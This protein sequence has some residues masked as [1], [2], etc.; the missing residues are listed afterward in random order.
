MNNTNN[1]NTNIQFKYPYI[2]DN[3]LQKKIALKKEFQYKYDD[4]IEKISEKEMCKTDDFVL[5]PHQEFVKMF[6]H[7]NTPYNGLL[8]FHGMGSGKT[9]S[10][11]GITEEFRKV[12]KYNEQFK[13]III[14]ASP[15]VQKNF[16]L[17]THPKHRIHG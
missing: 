16:Q 5:S 6:I 2:Q 3:Q 11:I 7:Y 14:I 17:Q 10:A 12:N 9:C 15:N 4:K 8:L 13:K 1:S